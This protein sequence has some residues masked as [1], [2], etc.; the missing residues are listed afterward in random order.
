V[1][2]SIWISTADKQN[3]MFIGHISG[4]SDQPA[5]KETATATVK[6]T[7]KKTNP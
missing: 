1:V 4:I 7:V 2:I 3:T 6:S 5:A